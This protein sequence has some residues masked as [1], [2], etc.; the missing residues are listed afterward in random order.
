MREDGCDGVVAESLTNMAV[1]A[2]FPDH[3]SYDTILNTT[4]RGDAD[5]P[6]GNLSS[7]LYYMTRCGQVAEGLT[8]SRGDVAVQSCIHI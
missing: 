2:D 7:A 5:V 6:E 8:K 3:E 4:M 1:F